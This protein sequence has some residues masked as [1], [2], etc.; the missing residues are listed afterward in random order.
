MSRISGICYVRVYQNRWACAKFAFW[1]WSGREWKDGEP[2]DQGAD[3][4]KSP[5]HLSELQACPFN[6]SP[7]VSAFKLEYKNAKTPDKQKQIKVKH[8]SMTLS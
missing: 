6:L 7:C 4:V 1:L 2:Q 3:F 8:P 5:F